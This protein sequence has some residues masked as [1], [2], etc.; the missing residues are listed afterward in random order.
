M[1]ATLFFGVL[2]TSGL[3]DYCRAGHPYPLVLDQDFSQVE[4]NPNT[5][6]PLGLIGEVQLDSQLVTIPIGGLAVLYSDGLSEALNNQDTQYGE[7]RL[8]ETMPKIGHLPAEEICQKLWEN[9]LTFIG[10]QPQSDDFTVVV[11]KRVG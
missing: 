8:L 11:I 9:V 4:I 6:M 1:F 7:K 5:G 10:D 2:D 3:L